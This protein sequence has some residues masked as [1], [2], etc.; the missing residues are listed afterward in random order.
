MIGLVG[1]RALGWYRGRNPAYDEAAAKAADYRDRDANPSAIM[2]AVDGEIV[3]VQMRADAESTAFAWLLDA[4]CRLR[5]CSF[6][7]LVV[8]PADHVAELR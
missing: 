1:R 8:L 5:S 2:I 3:G 6:D 7:S 4:D